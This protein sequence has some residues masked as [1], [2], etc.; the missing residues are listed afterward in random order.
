MYLANCLDQFSFSRVGYVQSHE[1]SPFLLV[2][3]DC[4][5]TANTEVLVCWVVWY[6]IWF[7]IFVVWPH[8]VFFSCRDR[9]QVYVLWCIEPPWVVRY[10][11]GFGV[12]TRKFDVGFYNWTM[13]Y[14][15]DSDVYFPYY[16]KKTLME[17]LPR[18]KNV[19]D[20]IIRKKKKMAVSYFNLRLQ[21]FS[22][23]CKCKLFYLLFFVVH[24]R[25]A[26][27]G[28]VWRN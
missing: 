16:L 1:C 14:R 2:Y 6:M 26:R 18:G 23:Y 28:N 8:L 21:C 27:N 25:L 17:E 22:F 3:C 11:K 24:R 15:R 7:I 12:D 4:T 9:D 20:D 5:K 13:T 10:F 19:V